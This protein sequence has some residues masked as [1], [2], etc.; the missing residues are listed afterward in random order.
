MDAIVL[1][2]VEQDPERRYQ[3][4]TE[5]ITDLEEVMLANRQ[6][7]TASRLAATMARLFATELEQEEQGLARV[8][9][10]QALLDDPTLEKAP[11]PAAAAPDTV[12]LRPA[13]AEAVTNPLG[14]SICSDESGRGRETRP[15]SSNTVIKPIIPWP[16]MVLN[17]SLWR[18]K[19]PTSAAG[20]DG[21]TSKA[22]Y[23]SGCPRGS[24]MSARRK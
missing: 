17:P 8:E 7:A 6:V 22:P 14:V 5:L 15:S 13:T 2:C 9:Q 21:D 19:T 24:S 23:I 18:N 10:S 4:A 1:R 11:Q 12:A 16:H 20:V 3:A